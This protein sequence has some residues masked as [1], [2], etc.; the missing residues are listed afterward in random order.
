MMYEILLRD[1]NENLP[2]ERQYSYHLRLQSHSYRN[3]KNR[4]DNKITVY[5]MRMRHILAFKHIV[6]LEIIEQMVIMGLNK[7]LIFLMQYRAYF[8]VYFKLIVV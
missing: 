6:P 3:S 2:A 5:G 8:I 4:L 7:L 1:Y